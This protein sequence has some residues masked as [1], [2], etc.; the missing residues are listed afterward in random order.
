M[1]DIL[2]E[3]SESLLNPLINLWNGLVT[4][5]PGI[6]ASLVVLILGWLFA[7]V[8]SWVVKHV[9]HKIKLDEHVIEKTHLSKHVGK[10]N[11]TNFLAT[12]TKWYVFILFL[13]SA[14]GLINLTKLSEFLMTVSLW[15]P[16]LIVAIVLALLGFL[17]I[18]YVGDKVSET[19]AKGAHL[20]AS[21]IKV[22]ILI[23]VAI[24]A[25][26]QVGINVAIAENS[27]LIILAGIML[28]LGLGFGLGLKDEAKSLISNLK[29]KF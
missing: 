2:S 23:F 22:I 5:L 10:F 16:N 7:V 29:K 12:I 9:L 8:I 25:L 1:F 17:T 19:K 15:V 26:E 21:V 18:E 27:F 20:I 6:L 28:A 4:T 14:A 13:P 11:L 3:T 24:I